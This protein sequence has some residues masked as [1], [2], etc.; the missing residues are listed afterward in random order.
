M[1]TEQ[2]KT[3][4]MSNEER[5]VIRDCSGVLDDLNDILQDGEELNIDDNYYD[6]GFVTEVLYFLRD[7][8]AHNSL[9]ATRG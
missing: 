7:L 1:T 5:A 2:I 6:K 3:I 8:H 4:T 9:T